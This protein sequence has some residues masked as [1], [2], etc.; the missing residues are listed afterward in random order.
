MS[1][2][3]PTY[4][5]QPISGDYIS[6]LGQ[7]GEI[8]DGADKKGLVSTTPENKDE[9]YNAEAQRVRLKTIASR[10][11]LLG[12][13]PKKYS[14][15]EIDG[16]L[17]KIQDAVIEFQGDA[18]LKKD[19]W[20]GDNTWYALEEL[21][22]FES[23]FTHEDWFKSGRIKPEVRIAVHRAVHLRL[24]ALGLID[25]RPRKDFK[26]V[27]KEDLKRFKRV[28]KI[29]L[30]KHIASNIDLNYDT[31]KILFN[32]DLLAKSIQKRSSEDKKSYQLRLSDKKKEVDRELSRRFIISCAKIELWLLG[33]DVNIN[34]RNDFHVTKNNQLYS[35][36]TKFYQEF[37]SYNLS[38]AKIHAKEIAPSFFDEI[39]NVID[40][41]NN[42]KIE[43]ASGIIEERIKTNEDISNAWSYI[44]KKGMSLWDGIKRVWR[45]IKKIGKKV[46][47]FI[48]KNI[49]KAF[50]RYTSKAF[51]IVKT[52]IKKLSNSMSIYFKGV[53]SSENMYYSF[54]KDMDT[55]VFIDSKFSFE[56]FR[57]STYKMNNQSK[58][59]RLACK[60]INLIVNGFIG[61]TA[62]FIGWAKFLYSLLKKYHELK[63]IYFDLK[64]II[65]ETE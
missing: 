13:L 12:Y 46:F 42:Y 22:S 64:S 58:I 30:I 41:T 59:F 27:V 15:S 21:V 39:V 63:F 25:D 16:N 18:C 32:Q 51:K 14:S 40:I 48:E 49:Y 53:I 44:K 29:F 65:N 52:A 8:F 24:W 38:T 50:F 54:S 2:E 9:T 43:D 23:D 19:K 60:I 4:N 5:F 36:L 6:K 45:W 17:N 20:V 26:P 11:W 57:N 61:L 7:F 28:L 55:E 47:N 31:L 33:F 1:N 3:L 56:N 62:G 10:L 35:S 34:G 37:A